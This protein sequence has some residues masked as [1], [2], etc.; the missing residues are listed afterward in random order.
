[1]AP[2]PA[3]NRRRAAPETGER[4]AVSRTRRGRGPPPVLRGRPAHHSGCSRWGLARSYPLQ[5]PIPRRWSTSPRDRSNRPRRS[6]HRI[7]RARPLYPLT[8]QIERF[9]TVCHASRHQNY[10]Q[11]GCTRCE[12]WQTGK[13]LVRRPL[14]TSSLKYRRNASRHPYSSLY[15]PPPPTTSFRS[16]GGLRNPWRMA[17]TSYGSEEQ[18]SSTPCRGLCPTAFTR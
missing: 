15:R 13:R 7:A 12:T 17:R 5:R 1:M 10:S 6:G 11:P 2:E 8:P 9:A 3:R 18:N 16:A 4:V 14:R